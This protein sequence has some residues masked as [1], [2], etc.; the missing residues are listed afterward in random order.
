MPQEY[1]QMT[2]DERQKLYKALS[3]LKFDVVDTSDSNNRT[4][5]DLLIIY[6]TPQDSP[7]AHWG[8]AFLPFHREWLKQLELA[9]R[10]VDPDVALPYFDSTLDEGLPVPADSVIWTD[11]FMGNG[12]DRTVTGPLAGCVECQVH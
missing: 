12:N 5:Y 3:Q 7:G 6:H 11:A 1:R 2:D 9:L 4:K 10:L 8:P